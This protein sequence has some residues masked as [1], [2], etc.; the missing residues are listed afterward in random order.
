MG[1]EN[2][3]QITGNLTL[4]GITKPITL[5]FTREHGMNKNFGAG[6]KLIGKIKRSDFGMG[7]FFQPIGNKVTLLICYNM[8]ECSTFD[9]Y[10]EKDSKYNQ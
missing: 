9:A 5:Y 8:A 2:I 1:L 4:L 6:F 7:T 3:G 10:Q